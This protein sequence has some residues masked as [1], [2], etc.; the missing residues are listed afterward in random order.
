M[1]CKNKGVAETE[2]TLASA[3]PVLWHEFY[4]RYVADLM[5][6]DIPYVYDF[7]RAQRSFDSRSTDLSR[8]E[9]VIMVSGQVVGIIG[10]KR[11]DLEK[12]QAEF[13]IALMDDAVKGKGI[14]T[15]AIKLLL[16]YAK[17]EL[18][19]QAVLA[20]SVHRNARS[21]HVLEKVGFV[22]THENDEFKFYELSL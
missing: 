15:Y 3:T 8:R 14:G 7:E 17:Y 18:K 4:S 6:T 19:L 2:V 9:F 13:G 21:Q 11:I 22:Y 1:S 20:D 16:E 5:M 12:N 10:L